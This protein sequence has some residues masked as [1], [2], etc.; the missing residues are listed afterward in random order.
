M[1]WLYDQ[2]RFQTDTA[3]AA[4]AVPQFGLMGRGL[5]LFRITGATAISGQD[6]RYLYTMR[7]SVPRNAANSWVPVDSQNLPVALG[8]SLSEMSNALSHYS[9]GVEKS[10][11]PVGFGAQRIPDD[12]IVAAFPIQLK[13]GGSAWVIV[14][15]QAVDGVCPGQLD[16]T[17]DGGS[18]DGVA[19]T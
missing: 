7:E 4:T 16:Y 6:E 10:N 1:S 2:R 3:R 19:E 17:V 12:T 15:T 11:L 14:N 8:L 13:D 18:Y 5:T 9:Y